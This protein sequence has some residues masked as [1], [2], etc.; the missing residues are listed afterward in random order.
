MRLAFSILLNEVKGHVGT[1]EKI[2]KTFERRRLVF[3]LRDREVLVAYGQTAGG[4]GIVE[5]PLALALKCFSEDEL[6]KIQCEGEAN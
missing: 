5:S 2:E 3:H 1:V 6:L 4:W